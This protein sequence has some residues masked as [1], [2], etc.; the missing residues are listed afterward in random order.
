M[1]RANLTEGLHAP[2]LVALRD[3]IIKAY[4]VPTPEALERIKT[5]RLSI[6]EGS[7]NAAFT[8]VLQFIARIRAL[9]DQRRLSINL[10]VSSLPDAATFDLWA[11]VGPHRTTTTNNTLD[12]VYR[13]L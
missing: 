6:T 13:K 4:P 12:N 7:K 3:Y 9:V 1:G 8:N 2:E 10:I 11:S 5:D